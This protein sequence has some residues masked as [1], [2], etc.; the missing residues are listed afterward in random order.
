[1]PRRAQRSYTERGRARGCEHFAR[2]DL[3][4][5][6]MPVTPHPE[7]APSLPEAEVRRLDDAAARLVDVATHSLD[8][9][10][11]FGW[12]DDAGRLTPG[13]PAETWVTCRMTHTF[14][15]AHLHGD[16]RAADLVDHG[17][18]A[19]RTTLHDDRHGGWLSVAGQGG[20]W[21]GGVCARLRRPGRRLCHGDGS[22]GRPGPA[23]RRARRHGR[24]VLGRARGTRRRPVGPRRGVA[25]TPI[26]ASTPTCTRSRPTLRAG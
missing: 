6:T 3:T 26:E 22:S 10:G 23:R 5:T 11:G 21:Q 24:P 16:A 8:P 9:A 2:T 12:L 25:S 17:V 19:L 1:M 15:L 20:R 14:A 18:Q 4:R 7:S 13:R